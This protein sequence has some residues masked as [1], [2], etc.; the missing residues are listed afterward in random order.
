MPRPPA[1]KCSGNIWDPRPKDPAPGDTIVLRVIATANAGETANGVFGRLNSYGGA[2]VSNG[3]VEQTALESLDGALPWLQG[4]VSCDASACDMFNQIA[5]AGVTPITV[6]NTPLEI[7]TVTFVYGPAFGTLYA[8]WETGGGFGFDFFGAPVPPD[9]CIVGPECPI[10]PE[11]AT[12]ALLGAG[13]LALR[14][15]ALTTAR[16]SGI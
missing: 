10:I 11:P 5:G 14:L 6:T 3:V 2:G 16:R 9:V 1:S 7:A 4:V 15:A 13:L 12:G 8:S